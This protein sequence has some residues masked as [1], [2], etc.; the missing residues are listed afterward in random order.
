[1]SYESFRPAPA[2]QQTVSAAA[3]EAAI[4]ELPPWMRAEASR[5]VSRSA[6][7]TGAAHL[8]AQQGVQQH[9]SSTEQQ[10][11]QVVLPF[12]CGRLQPQHHVLAFNCRFQVGAWEWEGLLLLINIRTSCQLTS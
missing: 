3:Q 7:S 11:L 10:D 2:G 6:D 5:S 4:R 8:T 9:A 12:M 1:M